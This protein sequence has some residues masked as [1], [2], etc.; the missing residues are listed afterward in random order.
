MND[1]EK[2]YL[3]QG[4]AWSTPTGILIGIALGYWAFA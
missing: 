4:I 3:Y 1:I 2:Y